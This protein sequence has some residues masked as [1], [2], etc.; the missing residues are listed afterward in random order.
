MPQQQPILA[1]SAV[2]Q[3]ST[4]RFLLVQRANPP[5]QGHWTLPGGRVDPGET[6]AEAAIREVYEETSVTIRVV[7]EL[8]QL[9]VPDGKGGLYEIHDFLAELVSGEAIA[10]DDAADVGWFS[11]DE[12]ETMTLTTDL[13]E[14]LARYGCIRNNKVRRSDVSFGLPPRRGWLR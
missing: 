4:G 6:L 9:T 1:A 11:P 3:D 2:I 7:R 14:Y 12:L 5:E 13:L 10:G 8:G